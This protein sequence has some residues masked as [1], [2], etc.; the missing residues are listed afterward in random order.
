MVFLK[1]DEGA[2]RPFER[3]IGGNPFMTET[4]AEP[5]ALDNEIGIPPVIVDRK[6]RRFSVLVG[7]DEFYD[8]LQ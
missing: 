7:F 2:H 6:D 8:F 1:M 3:W 5:G 4:R